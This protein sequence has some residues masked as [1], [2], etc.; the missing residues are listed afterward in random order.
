MKKHP[1]LKFISFIALFLFVLS[2]CE[3]NEELVLDDINVQQEIELDYELD[4]NSLDELD[5]LSNSISS[6]TKNSGVGLLSKSDSETV[7]D[8]N[9]VISVMDSV[10]NT[11]Y[12]LR[13]YVPGS[14][15]N[16]FHN[17]LVKQNH[18]GS[19]RAPLVMRYEI[20][21]EYYPTYKTKDRNEASFKGRMELY[22]LDG[23]DTTSQKHGKNQNSTPCSAVTVGGSTSSVV[24]TGTGGLEDSIGNTGTW[25]GSGVGGGSGFTDDDQTTALVEVG[26]GEF[27]DYGTEGEWKIGRISA[28]DNPCSISLLVPV[29]EVLP[30]PSCKSFDFKPVTSSGD[31][32]AA[33]VKDFEMGVG[34][35]TKNNGQSYR[36][37]IPLLT[38]ETWAKDRF[39]NELSPGA[40]A[41]LAAQAVQETAW[42][43]VRNFQDQWDFDE[44]DVTRWFEDE[45]KKKFRSLTDGGRVTRG[46]PYNLSPKKFET[47]KM[48]GCD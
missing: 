46:N 22:T 17:I 20:D 32:Q 31:W 1:F 29:N 48:N 27:G 16:V 12:A 21:E 9:H 45:L 15:Y 40:A 44:Y 11:T 35:L 37:R 43:T 18:D 30:A 3:R 42:A 34:T 39:N 4:F 7:I 8:N 36:I 6:I 47:G 26:Q 19:Y 23:F 33:T 38:F 14:P 28:K 41:E 25:T 5:G 13:M 24:G 2:A 10:G